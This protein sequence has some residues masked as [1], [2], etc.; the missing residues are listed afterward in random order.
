MQR[1]GMFASKRKFSART[2]SPQPSPR[3]R[4]DAPYN[5]FHHPPNKLVVVAATGAADEAAC[6]PSSTITPSPGFTTPNR[7]RSA[8]SKPLTDDSLA[9]SAFAL[10]SSAVICT[11]SACAVSASCFANRAR[12]NM[13]HAENA[14][15]P[16]INKNIPAISTRPEVRTAS[17]ARVY[18]FRSPIISDSIHRM[19]DLFSAKQQRNAK[20]FGYF[21]AV[22]MIFSMIVAYIPWK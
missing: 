22:F 14:E 4:R 20:V 3:E 19:F 18:R 8:A 13:P 7:C 21:V 11:K 15:R 12:T 6:A 9:T 1:S 16:A 17:S 10:L 5:P 2:P